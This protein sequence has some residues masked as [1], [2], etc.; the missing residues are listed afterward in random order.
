MDTNISEKYNFFIYGPEDEGSMLV[1]NIGVYLPI[2]TEHKPEET[3]TSLP[4]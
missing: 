1:V 2:H 4:S 3:W